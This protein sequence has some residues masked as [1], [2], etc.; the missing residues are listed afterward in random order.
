MNYEASRCYNTSIRLSLDPDALLVWVS[1][2]D[3]EPHEP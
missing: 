2:E 3:P 1:F